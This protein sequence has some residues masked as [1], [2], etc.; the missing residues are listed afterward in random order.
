[1]TEHRIGKYTISE[2]K[3]YHYKFCSMCKQTC[4]Y[5]YMNFCAYVL[6]ELV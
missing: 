2:N 5:K 6:E 3:D 1:M 4:Q